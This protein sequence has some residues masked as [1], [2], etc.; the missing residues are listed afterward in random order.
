VLLAALVWQQARAQNDC[1]PPFEPPT[2]QQT[3]AAKQTAAD[4]GYLWRLTKDGRSSYL[5]GTLHVARLA[6]IFPGPQLALALRN[7]DTL[8][9]ELN[10]SDPSTLERLQ[11]GI[12]ADPAMA[13]PAALQRRIDRAAARECVD[14]QLLKAQRLE[15]QVSTLTMAQA[16]RAGLE[17]AYGIDMLLLGV[18]Q[19]TAKPVVAL[20]TVE[21][22][23]RALLGESEQDSVA[24]TQ[25]GLEE[26]ES[27]DGLRLLGT[28]TD[29]WARND[30]PTLN[31]YLQWCDCVH[32]DAERRAMQRLLDARNPAMAQR[33]DALHRSGKRVFA[34]VGSLHM[35][36]SMGLP[37]QMQRLGY[38]VERV[39]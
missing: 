21:E 5:Y 36:G 4:R 34:A 2:P 7:T 37:T 8:A 1:P 12:A 29:A 26:L 23:L 25:D 32:S 20:E 17:P 33:L 27:G 14:A 10:L 19:R 39:F 35:I 22:Q 24:L 6:W 3:D 16:R 13:V 38:T 30:F 18:A 15:L 11:Q 9:L 31:S 28:L